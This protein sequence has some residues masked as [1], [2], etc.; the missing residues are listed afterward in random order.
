MP[1]LR[2]ALTVV[3]VA[4]VASLLLAAFLDLPDFGSVPHPYGARAVEAAL[5]QQTANAVA[6]VVFDQRGV[7]TLGEEFILFTAAVGAI[8][9]LRRLA[10]ETEADRLDEQDLGA[11]VFEAV[12]LV[13]MLMFPITV[14]VGAYVVVHGHVS[15]GGG[16]QGGV[17]LASGLHVAYL[18]GDIPV[19]R[20]LRSL[21]AVD[22]TEAVA[23]SGFVAV[24]LV[25]MAVGSA[26]LENVLPKGALTGLLSGGTVPLLNVVTGVEVT[27]AL[28]L[29]V[30]KF[31][32][33]G[34]LTDA[35]EGE[36]DA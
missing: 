15:P 27:A 31:L 23:A 19:L 2:V 8:L 29:L 14:L 9:L 21:T 16:F 24:G 6:S 34:L 32:E 33:Q 36:Q 1:R 26:F 20:R 7:D 30:G 10:D 25:A 5:D 12:R 3:G 35:G 22:V 11:G 18:A 4:G 28:V 17:I 13:G